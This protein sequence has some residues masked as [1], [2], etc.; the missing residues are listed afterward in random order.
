MLTTTASPT[1][2][3]LSPQ[4]HRCRC[5]CRRRLRCSPPGRCR[6]HRR[7][8]P[9]HHLAIYIREKMDGSWPNH[10]SLQVSRVVY[11]KIIF[12]ERYYELHVAGFQFQPIKESVELDQVKEYQDVVKVASHSMVYASL[13]ELE[14]FLSDG[15][16]LNG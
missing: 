11:L 16:Y 2:R 13:H 6:R 9:V 8:P 4:R 15:V 1:S 3:Y 14:V 10:T 12:Q 7:R 5:H